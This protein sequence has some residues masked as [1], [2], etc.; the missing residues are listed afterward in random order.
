MKKIFLLIFSLGL[1]SSANV[2]LAQLLFPGGDSCNTAVPITAGEGYATAPDGPGS[3]H[4]YSFIA[5]TT[6]VVI[7][8]DSG[9]YASDRRIHAGV[10]GSLMLVEESSW[11]DSSVTYP[12]MDGD[13]VF[14]EVN[15]SWDIQSEFDVEFD[16]TLMDISG[17]VYY[18]LNENGV[19]DIDEVGRHMGVMLSSPEGIFCS[20]SYDGLYFSSI[21]GLVDG[22]YQI[23]PDLE[24]RWRISSDSLVYNI[25]VDDD[26]EQRHDLNFGLFPD[27]LIYEVNSNTTGGWPRCNDTINYWL[28]VENSGTMLASGVMHLE[29]DDSLSYVSASIAP[30]SIVGQN[31]YWTYGEL[32][33]SELYSILVQV[34][35]PDGIADTLTSSFT[36]NIELAGVE[37]YTVTDMIEQ[38]VTCAYDPND[39]TPEPIGAGE[40]GYISPETETIDYLV[41]FQNTGTDTAITVIIKDQLD[42]HLDWYSITPLAYSHDMRLDMNTDGEVSFIFENI[43]LPDSNVNELASNGFVKYRIALN[44]ELPLGTSIYNTAHIYFDM[45]PAVLTNTTVNTL[46]VDESSS[47]DEALKTQRLLVYPNPFSDWTTVYFDA[48][49]MNYAVQIVDL[50]GNQVYYENDLSGN[51]L[52]IHA[53]QFKSGMYILSLIDNE[54]NAIV[55]NVKLIVK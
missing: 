4:W 8:S 6:G 37:M 10:C 32:F 11:A 17:S 38:V 44:P 47:I 46:H 35:T 31:I 43:M 3:S 13:T 12:M 18:D 40:F 26:F 22:A 2:S 21:S 1:I 16:S 27:T 5:P 7:V 45:N 29:L 39:K 53:A 49:L 50:L 28:H 9:P 19:R 54:V 20:T 42:E 15:D 30:D 25:T 34:A 52:K 24:E 33:F 48:D 14:I 51:E 23:M 55:S 36:T 41:R